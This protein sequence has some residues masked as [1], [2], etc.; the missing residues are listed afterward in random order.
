MEL[1]PRVLDIS[2]KSSRE[3]SKHSASLQVHS[4]DPLSTN[5]GLVWL[6]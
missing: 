1:Y 3:V 5:M 6:S 4:K 2:R